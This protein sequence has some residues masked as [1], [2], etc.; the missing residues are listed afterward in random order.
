MIV[1]CFGPKRFPKFMTCGDCSKK[2][3]IDLVYSAVVTLSL[4]T[5]IHTIDVPSL[6]VKLNYKNHL[7]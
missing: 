4:E 3:K 5:E 2:V 1:G 7:I 6:S